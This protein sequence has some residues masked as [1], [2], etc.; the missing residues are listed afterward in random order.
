MDVFARAD[1]AS[2]PPR[3]AR[4]ERSPPLFSGAPAQVAGYLAR[5][6]RPHP[7]THALLTAELS[8]LAGAGLASDSLCFVLSDDTRVTV[9]P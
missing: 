6:M 8:H 3:M 7:D 9:W 1:A 2:K 4:D 5:R